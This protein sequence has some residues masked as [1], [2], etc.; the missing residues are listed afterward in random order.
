M[1]GISQV[2]EGL[3]HEPSIGGFYYNNAEDSYVPFRAICVFIFHNSQISA[4]AL[5]IYCLRAQ[6]ANLVKLSFVRDY[7]AG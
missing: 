7:F 6:F 1:D 3:F 4:K 2:E 5:K